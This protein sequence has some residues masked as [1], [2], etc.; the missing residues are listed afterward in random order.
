MFNRPSSTPWTSNSCW[1]RHVNRNETPARFLRLWLSPWPWLLCAVASGCTVLPD[2]PSGTPSAAYSDTAGTTLGKL[3]PRSEHDTS[4]DS[5]ICIL[6][7]GEEAFLS[8]I[9]LIDLA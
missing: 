1:Q 3:A 6:D 7:R 9:A 5:A 4:P 2:K 8:R